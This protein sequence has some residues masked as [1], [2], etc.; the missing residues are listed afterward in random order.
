MKVQQ[1]ASR[2]GSIE[3]V[4][5]PADDEIALPLIAAWA[6]G[7]TTAIEQGITE[8]GDPLP[9]LKVVVLPPSK[10]APLQVRMAW[11]GHYVVKGLRVDEILILSKALFEM[12][13]EVVD[14]EGPDAGD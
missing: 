8:S 9:P 7:S 2:L 14:S 3:A 13:F 6:G 10:D 1:Y 12:L 11:P 5:V 4:Q